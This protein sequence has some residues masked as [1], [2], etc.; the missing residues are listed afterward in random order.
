MKW[1]RFYSSKPSAIALSGIVLL[2][3]AITACS[4]SNNS[5]SS[6]NGAKASNT[7]LDKI[8]AAGKVN[9][10]LVQGQLPYSDLSSTGEAGGYFVEVAKAALQGIGVNEMKP[11]ATGWDGLIPGL[12]A[13][14]WDI[15]TTALN[16]TPERCK[17][18]IF[19]RPLV[20]QPETFLVPK[21]NPNNI[22]S[23]ADIANNKKIKLAEITGSADELY[24]LNEA[25]IPKSQIVEAV[26]ETTLVDMMMTGRADAAGNTL[27][28]NL[29]LSKLHPGKFDIVTLTD[30]KPTLEG[31]GF[32]KSDTALR[33]AVDAS[34]GKLIDNGELAK[35]YEKW[36]FP[37]SADLFKT[38]R[39]D[40]SPDC[41]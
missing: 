25:K 35:I 16:I 22:T 7:T 12:E 23:H 11:S 19:S 18:I 28:T 37:N 2:S 32:R 39:T 13:N 20:L 5:D 36:G 1:T 24:A 40:V 14:R 33:D 30:V 29:T 4:S 26:D 15:V 21:G 41:V 31:I 6:S 8:K 3:I 38:A 17:V 9:V 10:G 34:I 27:I